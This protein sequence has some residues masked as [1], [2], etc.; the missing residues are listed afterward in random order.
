MT[1]LRISDVSSL[2]GL[3]RTTLW[4]LERRNEFPARI[5]LTGHSIGWRESE[6]QEWISSRPRGI[7]ASLP[8]AL[9][10]ERR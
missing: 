4:R 7:S 8:E 10:N 6:V 5:R 2:T 1:I 9:A 3:S